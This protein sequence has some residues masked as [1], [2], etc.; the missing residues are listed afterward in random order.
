[1][2]SGPPRVEPG[3]PRRARNA[4]GEGGR[5]R[6]ELIEAASHLI[7]EHGDVDAASIRAVARQA[8]V[9]APSVYLH[10]A[11]RDALVAAVVARRFDD[12]TDAIDRALASADAQSSPVAALRAGCRAYVNY[13]VTNPGHYRVLFDAPA[14]IALEGEPADASQDAL[15]T[16]VDVIAAC[17]GAGAARSGDTFTLAVTLWAAMHGL[18]M[19]EISGR[20]LPESVRDVMLDAMIA[21]LVGV[22]LA[23]SPRRRRR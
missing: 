9:S 11:D 14:P 6:D 8:G 4:R 10:F 17:Q 1:M 5:L 19:L 16:L 22:D 2:R 20:G 23:A 12:L 18:V 15:G 21:G 3:R 13:G 7:A